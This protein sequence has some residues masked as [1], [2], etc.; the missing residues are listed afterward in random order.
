MLL[1]FGASKKLQWNNGVANPTA[2][3]AE[4][5]SKD[6]HSQVEISKTFRGCNI[7]IIVAKDGWNYP[8]K[9]E[10]VDSKLKPGTY[11]R[12]TVSTRG[13]NVRMSMNGPLKL[14]FKEFEEISQA[15]AEAKA[16]L[17]E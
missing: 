14:R 17:E 16:M 13:L 8:P 6:G 11:P 9:H 10:T 12:N 15:V 3:C 7:V 2:W 5:V 4:L 1:D